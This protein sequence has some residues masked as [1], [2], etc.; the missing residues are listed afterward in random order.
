MKPNLFSDFEH[1]KTCT[2]SDLTETRKDQL[3]KFIQAHYLDSEEFMYDIK[4]KVLDTFMTGQKYQSFVSC[5]FEKRLEKSNDN[6]GKLVM[7]T[8]YDKEPISCILMNQQFIWFSSWKHSEETNQSLHFPIYLWDYICTHRDH[9]SK[10]LSRNV[11]Q[12]HIYNQIRK[13]PEV[14]AGI[15][16]KE[17]YLCPGVI[18]LVQYKTYTFFIQTTPITKLPIGYKIKRLELRTVNA[19]IELYTQLPNMNC[20]DVCVMP[21]VNNT[22]ECISNE[23]HYVI[24]LISTLNGK[25]TVKGLY[26][27]KDM[28]T[29]W[30]HSKLKHK[31]TI[32]CVSSVCYNMSETLYFFRGFLHSIKEIYYQKKDYGVLAIEHNSHNGYILQRWNEKYKMHMSTQTAYYLYNMMYPK[33]SIE[34]T[35]FFTF[36]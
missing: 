22:V 2:Y 3:I 28:Y 30:D 11:I 20:F 29:T 21:S 23:T 16:K 8:V 24:L 15:F 14:E 18:P 26:I 27:F 36:G 31:R 12:T 34:N 7:K 17:V 19:W 25:E 10:N 33:S 5:Y 35:R 6:Q 1:V 32:Q 9:Q 4:D 13:L